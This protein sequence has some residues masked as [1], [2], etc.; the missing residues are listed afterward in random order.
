MNQF[1]SVFVVIWAVHHDFAFGPFPHLRTG[2][3]FL[4]VDRLRDVPPCVLLYQH[5]LYYVALFILHPVAVELLQGLP[6]LT[7]YFYQYFIILFL[8]YPIK[9]NNF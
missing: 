2:D 9:S 8:A 6:Q 3:L 7:N 1:G 5:E 4:H